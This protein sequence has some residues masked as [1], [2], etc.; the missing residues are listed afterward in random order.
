MEP[1]SRPSRPVL[2]TWA[3]ILVVI[4]VA[5]YRLQS[6][7]PA[8]PS[9]PPATPQTSPSGAVAATEGELRAVSAW[10]P[11][12]TRVLTPFNVQP[13]GHSALWVVG[14]GSQRVKL[15]LGGTVLPT[16]VAPNGVTASVTPELVRT[17]T[18]QRGDLPV[19]LVSS[20]GRRQ[21]IG[22]FQILD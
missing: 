6:P 8:P 22:V 15:E 9:P 5:A 20:E 21:Q 14:T 3:I 13:N 7:K 17:I 11:R 4:A 19:Y 1:Q 16:V 12:S 18:A 10:G 2:W